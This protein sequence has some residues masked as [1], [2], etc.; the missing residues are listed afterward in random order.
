LSNMFDRLDGL[1]QNTRDSI[2][3]AV[4]AVPGELSS[5]IV[6][7]AWLAEAERGT[8]VWNHAATCFYRMA[9]QAGS[10]GCRELALRCHVARS[11]TADEYGEQPETALAMLDEAESLLG[12]DP[13]LAR[14][15]AKILWRKSDYAG[16]LPLLE[17]AIAKLPTEGVI[18]KV[19]ML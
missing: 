16:A 9:T 4:D 13:I 10:W 17:H 14:A 6:N 8:L 19:F 1:D 3:A 12:P 7:P 2:F 11:V 5:M 18:E 15:R